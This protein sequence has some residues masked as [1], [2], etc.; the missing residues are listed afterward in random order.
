MALCLATSFIDSK[1]FDATDQM[2][3]YV[4]WWREGYMSSTGRCFDIGG[5][6]RRALSQ[7][8]SSGEPHA[9]STRPDTAGNG[10]LMRLAPMPIFYA[11]DAAEAIDY[12]ELS[13]MT[14]HQ[15]AEAVDACRYYGGLLAGALNGVERDV[16][17][18]PGYCPVDGL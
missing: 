17:L 2:Q 8:Q 3:R 4:H 11:G 6:V 7:F 13:S 10:S 18:A 15:A 12:S 5:T 9:G 14:T 1:G 16:L